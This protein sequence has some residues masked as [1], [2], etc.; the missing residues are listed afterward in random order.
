MATF[1]YHYAA[2]SPPAPSVLLNVSRPDGSRSVSNLAAIADTV[3]DVTVLPLAKIAELG[4]I[5]FDDEII[6]AFDGTS[7]TLPTYYVRLQ[8][9]DFPPVELAMVGSDDVL[10]AVLG[11]DVLNRYKIILDGPRQTLEISDV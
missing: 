9:R 6:L 10:D 7:Q 8:V 3:A 1:K 4:L 2:A 5:Q 11:R